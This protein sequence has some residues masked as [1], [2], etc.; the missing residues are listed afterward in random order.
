LTLQNQRLN[1]RLDYFP[2][3]NQPRKP[4]I[5]YALLHHQPQTFPWENVPWQ[6][7]YIKMKRK[8]LDG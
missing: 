6:I 2:N 4:Q 8:A 3:P 1:L 7:V 5:M